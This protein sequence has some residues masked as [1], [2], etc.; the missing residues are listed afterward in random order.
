[1]TEII[2]KF[3]KHLHTATGSGEIL[4]DNFNLSRFKTTTAY[5]AADDG[6]GSDI[7][8][9]N[10]FLRAI[11]DGYGHGHEGDRAGAQDV[12]NKLLDPNYSQRL[13]RTA[14]FVSL[15]ISYYQAGDEITI[16]AENAGFIIGWKPT[17]T[18]WLPKILYI[19]SDDHKTAVKQVL[20]ID[21]T[22]TAY[23]YF[24]LGS[25][26]GY[27]QLA[28]KNLFGKSD[29]YQSNFPTLGQKLAT[30][31]TD[32]DDELRNA[33]LL[34][35]V[36]PITDTLNHSANGFGEVSQIINQ[37]QA[38]LQVNYPK[39]PA[40]ADDATLMFTRFEGYKAIPWRYK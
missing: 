34:A 24:L 5:Q 28:N 31:N 9:A 22:E 17:G 36:M 4:Q 33:A 11:I 7:Y 18:Q 37:Y 32:F 19:G 13:K 1:M 29:H 30:E 8:Y 21:S 10:E 14:S 3:I 35:L 20:K 15:T 25:D 40:F 23:W 16:N 27:Y 12:L 38:G 6:S 39:S 2:R 26:G